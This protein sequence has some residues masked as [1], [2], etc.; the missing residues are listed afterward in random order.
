M[1]SMTGFGRVEKALETF[2]LVVEVKTV[3]GR[4]FDLKPRV[5]REMAFLENEFRM[6]IQ[7]SLRRGRTE[8]L[9]ELREKGAD[10]FELNGD[11]IRSYLGL[12]DQ[13]SEMGVSGSLSVSDLIR[14]PEVILARKTGS[15]GEQVLVE[16]KEAVDEAVDLVVAERVSE[17]AALHADL[18]RRIRRL[19]EQVKE[20]ARWASES[21]ANQIQKLRRKIEQ[22][23]LEGQVDDSRLAQEILFHVERADISEEVTR[24]Q[25]HLR[26]FES[27]L[28]QETEEPMGKSLDFLCQEM[29]REVNTVLAKASILEMSNVAVQAKAEIERIREQVQ[30]VE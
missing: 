23:D 1:R 15:L 18:S 13:M 19:E 26:K 6:E 21:E 28:I 17:G 8:L 20:I 2:D 27:Y 3:N 25:S 10:R 9:I 11:L 4:Y 5:P 14:M 30:N 16:L 12:A 22:H 29:N 7:K 24:L